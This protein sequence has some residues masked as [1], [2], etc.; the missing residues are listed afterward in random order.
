MVNFVGI[1]I[2]TSVFVCA[3]EDKR[4]SHAHTPHTHTH[5]HT[6]GDELMPTLF[7]FKKK[8]TQWVN[9]L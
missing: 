9:E 3:G 4:T 8:L 7:I 5:Q 6:N 1:S 2:Y